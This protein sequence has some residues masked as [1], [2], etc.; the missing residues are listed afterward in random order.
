[1]PHGVEQLGIGKRGI[2]EAEVFIGRA[3]AAQQ[4]ARRNAHRRDQFLKLFARRRGLQILDDLRLLSLYRQRC[5]PVIMSKPE[6]LRL[7][8]LM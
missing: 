5:Y 3:L 1:M 6:Q 2:I 7:K 4:V 8:M